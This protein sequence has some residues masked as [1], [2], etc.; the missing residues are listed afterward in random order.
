MG[1]CALVAVVSNKKLYTIALGTSQAAV[2]T[3]IQ[4]E[5]SETTSK[6]DVENDESE[7]YANRPDFIYEDKYK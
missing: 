2:L 5:G 1:T 6:E 3:K 7:Y 4:K